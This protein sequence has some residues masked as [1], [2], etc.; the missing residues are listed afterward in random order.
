MEQR[1]FR[2]GEVIL[3]L[4]GTP[5][6]HGEGP[7]TFWGLALTVDDLDAAATHLGERLGPVT[8]AVQ[9]GRRIAT[10]RHEAVGLHVPIA[11]LTAA[12]PRPPS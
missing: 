12:P 11:F 3:E 9:R 7:A 8:D 1:F 4:V 5:G 10:L 6:A 2:L